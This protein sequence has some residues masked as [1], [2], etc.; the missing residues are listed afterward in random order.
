MADR[1]SALSSPTDRKLVGMTF[2]MPRDWHTRF[3]VAA[4]EEGLSMKELLIILFEQWLR[5]RR[6]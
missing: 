4:I 2:N 1:I 5:R 6:G 3:K